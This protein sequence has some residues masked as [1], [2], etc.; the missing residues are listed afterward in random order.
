MRKTMS[1]RKRQRKGNKGAYAMGEG[2]IKRGGIAG[3]G[4]NRKV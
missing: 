3:G 1:G 4:K 2:G